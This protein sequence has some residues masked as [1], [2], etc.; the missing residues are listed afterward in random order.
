MSANPNSR[1]QAAY[2]S[3]AQGGID[4]VPSDTIDL[5]TD[6]RALCIGGAG[7][8]KVLHIDGTTATYYNRAAGSD[9]IVAAR[10]IYATGTTATLI[11]AML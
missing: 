5:A 1:E 3:S 6:A 7:N 2:L 8:V 10:R 9:L 11:T 4:V